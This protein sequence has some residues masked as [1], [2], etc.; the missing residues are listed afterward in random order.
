MAMSE[1]E[2]NNLIGKMQ[3]IMNLRSKGYAVNFDFPAIVVIGSQ[4]SGKSSVIES[5]IGRHLLPRG[6]NMVTRCPVVINLYH[7]EYLEKDYAQF[8]PTDWDQNPQRIEDFGRVRNEIF[9]RMNR[10]VNAK[11]VTD[12]MITLNIHSEYYPNNLQMIGK[13]VTFLVILGFLL[14]IRNG[15]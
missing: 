5:I 9:I 15:S 7:E 13:S 12:E 4:S 14:T 3:K 1:N 11:N 8:T 10:L 2:S 6:T